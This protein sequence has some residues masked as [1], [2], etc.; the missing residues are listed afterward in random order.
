MNALEPNLAALGWFVV[1]FGICCV[2]FFQLSGM[3]PLRREAGGGAPAALVLGSS[4]LW[5]AVLAGTLL[6][7]FATLRPTTTIV[8]GGLLFLF[9]PELFQALPQRWRDSAGGVAGS[10]AVLALALVVLAAIGAAPIAG[11]IRI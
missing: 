6:Y 11:L 3:Y 2:G 1:F 8:V 7:A 10:G 4:A 5:I 9:T